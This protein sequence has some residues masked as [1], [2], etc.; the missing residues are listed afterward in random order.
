MGRAQAT[1]KGFDDAACREITE[2]YG[3]A[4]AQQDEQNDFPIPKAIDDQ[5]YQQDVERKPCLGAADGPHE[6]IKPITAV[7]VYPE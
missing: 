2:P 6:G 5:S 3:D 1:D 7:A 4:E